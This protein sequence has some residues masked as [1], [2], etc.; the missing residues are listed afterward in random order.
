MTFMYPVNLLFLLLAKF[1]IKPVYLLVT[2]SQPFFQPVHLFT[3]IFFLHTIHGRFLF[4]CIRLTASDIPV[5][6][7][8]LTLPTIA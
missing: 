2:L 5:S 6:Y 4:P 3:A 8:H 7:T 1:N